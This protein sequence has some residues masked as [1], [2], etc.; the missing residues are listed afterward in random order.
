M[1]YHGSHRPNNNKMCYF[2]TRWYEDL[3]CKEVDEVVKQRMVA[4][5][6]V[7]LSNGKLLER[8]LT[9]KMLREDIPKQSSYSYWGTKPKRNPDL[10]KATFIN[11]LIP[12]AESRLED[13]K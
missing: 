10:T 5:E 1:S 8:L 6:S 4:G 13:I 9:I 12:L 11:D 3:Q 2:I 7:T